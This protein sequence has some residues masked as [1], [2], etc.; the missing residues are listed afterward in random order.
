M[1]S[2]N[3][4]A[5]FSQGWGGL[6]SVCRLPDVPIICLSPC[7]LKMAKPSG[8]SSGS[9]LVLGRRLRG[10]EP[11]ELS[12][13][14]LVSD[15]LL[16]YLLNTS[17]RTRVTCEFLFLTQLAFYPIFMGLQAIKPPNSIPGIVR[18][19]QRRACL[20]RQKLLFCSYCLCS[21]TSGFVCG[22]LQAMVL[23]DKSCNE[24]EGGGEGSGRK[25]G[26]E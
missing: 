21:L 1:V 17:D 5:C 9:G 19:G 7:K 15:E 11:R 14:P 8:S 3:T 24:R 22:R 10:P 12:A 20:R 6:R 26:E 25:Q 16:Q 2:R 18:T 13:S 4:P 23:S